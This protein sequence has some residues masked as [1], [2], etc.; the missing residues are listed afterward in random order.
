M[1]SFPWGV[2]VFS[3]RV[4]KKAAAPPSPLASGLC[5]SHP[6]IPPPAAPPAA[7]PAVSTAVF[8]RLIPLKALMAS[9]CTRMLLSFPATAPSFASSQTPKI[10]SNAPLTA[11]WLSMNHCSPSATFSR[12]SPTIRVSGSSLLCRSF[13]TSSRMARLSRI[14][15][16][17][18]RKNSSI[19]VRIWSSAACFSPSFFAFM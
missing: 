17:T 13:P 7:P 15:S 2:S 9:I 3:N 5:S 18:F 8:P 14:S 6:R 19:F 10:A 4:P 11:S 12:M 1:S 16:P